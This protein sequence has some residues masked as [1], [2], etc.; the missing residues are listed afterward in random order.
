MTASPLAIFQTQL[1]NLNTQLDMAEQHQTDLDARLQALH[2]PC[3]GRE[4]QGVLGKFFI[5]NQNFSTAMARENKYGIAEVVDTFSDAIRLFDRFE[6]AVSD[7][8]QFLDAMVI[9]SEFPTLKEL[10][11]DRITFVRELRDLTADELSEVHAQVAANTG[12]NLGQVQK[13]ALAALDL[14]QEVY[15]VIDEAITKFKVIKDKALAIAA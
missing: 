1:D 3:N 4:F 14:A 6:D 12:T 8:I 7:G 11:D 15:Q 9:L 5:P 13:K 2:R 10:Y